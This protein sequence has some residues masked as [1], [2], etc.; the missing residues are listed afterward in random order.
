M[1]ISASI[2]RRLRRPRRVWIAIAVA[3]GIL[4]GGRQYLALH[5][6]PFESVSDRAK[7]L[8]SEQDI[9][10][11]YGH[12]STFF[13]APYGPADALI[14][15]MQMIGAAPEVLAPAL[16]GVE[17]ALNMYPPRFVSGIVGAIFIAGDLR[18]GSERAGGSTGPAWIIL[19][20][21]DSFGSDGVRLNAFEGVHH[22]LSS[23]VLQKANVNEEWAAFSPAGSA[24]TNTNERALA[25]GTD[26]APSPETGF[27]SAY[28]ATTAEN[29]FN[30][31]AERIFTDAD[32]LVALACK[33]PLVRKKLLFVLRT[34]VVL[35]ERMDRVFR[36]LGV[37][38]AHL[39]ER[40][41]RWPW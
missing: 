4:E 10:I 25:R 8:S 17:A 26:P 31:Y 23:F 13:V 33:H 19:A 5:S 28:A 21:P 9:V 15:D 29:D 3:A 18:V 22:E 39:C 16:E 32:T 20:A 24:F 11:S 35:D 1:G 40:R 27:L 41:W 30:T 6:H 7:R 2:R 14:D 34:Y 38:G 37:D 12:P 36:E